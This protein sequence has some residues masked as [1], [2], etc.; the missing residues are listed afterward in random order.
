MRL[1]QSGQLFTVPRNVYVLGTMNTA[2]RSIRLLDA[3]LR[4]RF[5]FRELLPDT[6]PLE[7]AYVGKLHLAD[8]LTNLNSRVRAEVGRERQIGQAFLL[9]EGQPLATDE[10]LAATIREDIIPLLQEYAYDD[11]SMLTRILG[12][13]VVDET[14]QCIR[15]LADADLV[16]ALYAELQTT[17][18]AETLP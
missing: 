9:R 13:L 12:S 5:A 18:S 16:D 17:P 6:E 15:Q 14:Q 1:P 7:G 10:E 11:Y 2:D 4:R 3:A 8:L